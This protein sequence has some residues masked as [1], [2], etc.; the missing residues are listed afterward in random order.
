[1]LDCFVS[2]GADSNL[3]LSKRDVHHKLIVYA[4]TAS[5][6]VSYPRNTTVIATRYLIYHVLWNRLAESHCQ[7][8]PYFQQTFMKLTTISDRKHCDV[9]FG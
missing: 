5:N 7:R 1:M 6:A 9:S 8:E 2:G 4:V 3:L